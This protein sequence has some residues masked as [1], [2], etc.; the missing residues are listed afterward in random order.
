MGARWNK[1]I[2]SSLYPNR[3]LLELVE[4]R[5]KQERLEREA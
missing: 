5:E 4:T 2:N 1:T 3:E